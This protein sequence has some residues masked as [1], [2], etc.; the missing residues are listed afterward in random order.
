[1]HTCF[2]KP[3]PKG[4]APDIRAFNELKSY[5]ST[6]G[7]THSVSDQAWNIPDVILLTRMPSQND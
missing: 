7:Y 5:L 2:T 1:M 3:A 6:T 4:A